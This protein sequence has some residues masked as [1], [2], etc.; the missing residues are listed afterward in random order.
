MPDIHFQ[1]NKRTYVSD[2]K[3]F[4]DDPSVVDPIDDARRDR[5]EFLVESILDHRTVHFS[6]PSQMT[7]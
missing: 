1:T 4:L 2:L 7:K 3:E 6:V 5:M